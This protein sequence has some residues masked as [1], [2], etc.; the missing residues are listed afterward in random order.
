MLQHS[1]YNGEIVAGSLLISESRQIARLLLDGAN[2]KK[3]HRKIAVENILQK[4]SSKSAERQARLIRNRLSM[5]NAELWELII[6]GSFETAT[7]AI[8]A[9]SIKHN[10][11]IGDFMDTVIRQH[12]QTFKKNISVKDWEDFLRTCAQI[13]PKVDA[14][15]ANTRIKLRQVVFRILAESGYIENTRTCLLLPV[16]II[17]EIRTFLL[18]NNKTY[19]LRCM[20]ITPKDQ[21]DIHFQEGSQKYKTRFHCQAPYC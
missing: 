19:V 6:N 10:H 7:Q 8:L 14:W 21:T 20:D 4:K 3:W 15:S 9:A 1:K 5:V 12:W 13:N 11:L 2:D 17:P 18:N 16:T